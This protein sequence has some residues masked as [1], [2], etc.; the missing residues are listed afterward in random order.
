M[1]GECVIITLL[2]IFAA[3]ALL[4]AKRRKWAMAILPL[5]VLPVVSS[6]AGMVCEYMLKV[7]FRFIGAVIAIMI[8]LIASC[9]WI[10]FLAATLL[11][12]RKARVPYMVG[13]IAFDVILAA[14]ILADYYTAL[15][16]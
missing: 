1:T 15:P 7:E 6:L 12:K 10:G 2:L 11:Q 5:M 4:R 3:L 8:A 14:V 9:T 16:Q 13:C